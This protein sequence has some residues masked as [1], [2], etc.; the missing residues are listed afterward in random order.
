MTA[1]RPRRFDLDDGL[2]RAM[3]VF[4]R[5]G[6]EG[7][8]LADLTR[9]MGI[10]KPSLYAAYGNKETLF[11]KAVD[12]YVDGPAHHLRDA[13]EQP[14]ARAVAERLLRG[15]AEVTTSPDNPGAGCLVVQ[16]AL[17]TGV[18]GAPAR[19]ELAARRRAGEERLRARFEQARADGD[20][21]DSTDAADLARY[22]TT[23]S[24]GLSVQAADGATREDLDRAVDLA[25][26]TWPP[27][28]PTG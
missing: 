12:R 22:V 14:T 4:W 3:R 23:L 26:R 6:Y 8:G 9:A 5:N 25:L 7:S 11:R 19:E 28:P 2:D 20:L 24:Y 17:A 1:G 13:L 18:H 10:N 21:P 16:G 15:A 27:S